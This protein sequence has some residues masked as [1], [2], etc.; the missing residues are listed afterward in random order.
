MESLPYEMRV[1]AD[2]DAHT[3]QLTGEIDYASSLDLRPQ[4][5]E[6][7]ANCCNNLL[8]DL[9]EVSFID[10]EGIKTLIAMVSWMQERQG[11]ARI[12]RCSPCVA[13]V[14][15]IVGLDYLLPIEQRM[16]HCDI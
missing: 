8:I 3:V 11:E 2:P 10:S 6:L 7:T 13:R 15:K 5:H 4:L 14:L 16:A 12:V 9:N 1:I